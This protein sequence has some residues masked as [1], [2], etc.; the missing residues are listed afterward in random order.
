MPNKRLAMRHT[1]EI[2]RLKF[3]AKLS[4]RK[5]AR[6]LNIGVGTVS[7]YSRRATDLGV[8]WPL[9]ADMSDNDLE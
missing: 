1:K 9:P 2:L 3:E 6:C 4:H 8:S 7:L 5:I